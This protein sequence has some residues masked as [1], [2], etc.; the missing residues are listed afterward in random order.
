[1]IHF[2][3]EMQDLTQIEA[4]L[5]MMKDKSKMVLRTAINNAAKQTEN[6]MVDG[7]KS[8][9]RYKSGTKGDIRA[10]NKITKAKTSALYAMVEAQGP[11]NELLDFMVRPSTYFRGG[12]GAP[13]W[14]K[15]RARRDSS[16][17]KLALR[18]GASG[19]QY[20]GFVIRY[21]NGHLAIAQRVPG[22]RMRS[23]Y[24]KE[25]VKSLYSSSTPKMEEIAYN[26]D[27]SGK[28]NDMLHRNIQEQIQ[29]LLK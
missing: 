8:R 12:R 16:L 13:K 17:A 14:V 24:R 5:G 20:K 21:R 1:M 27:V 26:E 9:F 2:Q 22:K 4:A 15:V 29:R 10:A 23:N 3:V 11:V 19:D 28:V 18:P 25:A 7:A 6:S